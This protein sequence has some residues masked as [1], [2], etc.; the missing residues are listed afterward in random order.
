MVLLVI[1]VGFLGTDPV[2]AQKEDS[3]KE[4][5]PGPAV[6]AV[7]VENSTEPLLLSSVHL[8]DYLGTSCVQGSGLSWFNGRRVYVP[9]SKI[10]TVVEIGTVD[11][12]EKAMKEK[13]K[14]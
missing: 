3:P 14:H 10:T 13:A 4:V 7:Y 1:T 12:F 9:V 6:C 5:K 11:N 2:A 8:V